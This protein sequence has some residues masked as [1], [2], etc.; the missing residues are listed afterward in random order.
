[1]VFGKKREIEWAGGTR[2][3]I[4]EAT[5]NQDAS[6]RVDQGGI[7]KGNRCERVGA[8]RKRVRWRESKRRGAGQRR[9]QGFRE[10]GADRV[11]VCKG[12]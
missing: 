10:P 5:R 2:D 1:V 6:R 3:W 9:L 4:E 11:R 8:K 12:A 7:G